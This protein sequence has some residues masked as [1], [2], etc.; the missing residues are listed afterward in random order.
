MKSVK[1]GKF[2]IF[3]VYSYVKG[4]AEGMAEDDAKVYGFSIAV[5][6]ARARMGGGG[7]PSGKS[8]VS[9][10]AEA[11]GKK[12]KKNSI[13]VDDYD[14][15]VTKMGD[16]YNMNFLPGMKKMFESGLSYDEVKKMVDIP[17]T[18]GAK[19]TSDEFVSKVSLL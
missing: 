15:L 18:I 10:L 6:G 1:V 3:A 16:F 2:D 7:R 14:K 17:S 11:A 19:I 12:K 8:D 4:M 13:T 9:V 5:I